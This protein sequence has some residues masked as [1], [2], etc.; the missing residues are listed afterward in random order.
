MRAE[1]PGHKLM[2]KIKR[3]GH[4]QEICN[5]V[6]HL[7]LHARASTR[8]RSAARAFPARPVP[9]PADRPPIAQC[10]ETFLFVQPERIINRR[11][12]PARSEMLLQGVPLRS[13]DNILMIDVVIRQARRRGKVPPAA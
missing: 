1:V 3:R 4:V 2:N 13:A 7:A 9:S 11:P 5:R 6:D 10:S 12:N 8:D